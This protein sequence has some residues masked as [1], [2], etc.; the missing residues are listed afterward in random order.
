MKLLK[1]I[2]FS[3]LWKLPVNT[4]DENHIV[5]SGIEVNVGDTCLIIGSH[6]DMHIL[7]LTC[8]KDCGVDNNGRIFEL[9]FDDPNVIIP[10]INNINCKVFGIF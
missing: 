10:V 3:E 9:I 2:A 6:N 1:D 5:I 8:I 7:T 4:I